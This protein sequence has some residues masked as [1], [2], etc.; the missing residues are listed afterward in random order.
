MM[1]PLYRF[2]RLALL[3]GMLTLTCAATRA[4][5]PDTTRIDRLRQHLFYLASD[6]LRGRGSGT[7]DA[8]KAA[9]YI[10]AQY[11]AMGVAPYGGVW[12]HPFSRRGI[13]TFINIVGVI[14]GCDATLKDE[15]IVLGAHYDHIGVKNNTVYNGADDNASGSAA[16]IEIAR[17][18]CWHR[19][20]LRRSILIAAFDGEELGLF[21]SDELSNR[22][23][24][25]GVNVRLMMSIDMVGWLA[26]GGAL[27]LM[28]TGTIRDGEEILTEAAEALSLPVKLIGFEKSIFTATDTEGFATKGIPTLAVTT[29]LKSPYH[30]PEDDAELIDYEGLDVVTQYLTDITLRFAADEAF[31]PSGR[32][33]FKHEKRSDNS[34]QAGLAAGFNNSHEH[35]PKAAFK[36]TG[37]FGWNGG[38]TLRANWKYVGV[39]ADVLYTSCTTPL[40][41]ADNL[42]GSK[43][44]WKHQSLTVPVNIV[45]QTPRSQRSGA[46][47]GAGAYYS[48]SFGSNI[49]ELNEAW[50]SR[51]SEVGACWCFGF[52]IYNLT[53]KDTFLMGF[54]DSLNGNGAPSPARFRAAVCTLCW[55]F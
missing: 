45:F 4:E 5:Q 18:L 33:S 11:E 7:V 46:F 39:L 15:Y 37:G 32:V 6:S 36:G 30:K 8:H 2:F 51:Q 17:E 27:K 14:P 44:R 55:Y 16:L 49:G 13:D 41:D 35:Y 48:H 43:L 20:E 24:E 22:L 40:P 1:N 47:I 23:E 42:Y 19:A 54:G 38:V 10:R 25:E 12:E 29:G 50:S 53:V 28:G 31:G 3:A 9:E 26:K 21:G 52:D 34:V